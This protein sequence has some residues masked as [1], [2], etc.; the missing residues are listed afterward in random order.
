M[1]DNDPTGQT[2]YL[3]FSALVDAIRAGLNADKILAE[4]L[5]YVV[6]TAAHSGNIL[7]RDQ[8]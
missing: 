6:L 4:A 1:I 7:T 2:M 8:S 3:A 5:D